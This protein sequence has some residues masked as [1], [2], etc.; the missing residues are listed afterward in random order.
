MTEDEKQEI[1]EMH[2]R[3]TL[4]EI[5]RGNITA[6]LSLPGVYEILTEHYNNEVMGLI[7]ERHGIDQDAEEDDDACE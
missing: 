3:E 2:W 7:N 6:T 5:A 1:Y 4:D